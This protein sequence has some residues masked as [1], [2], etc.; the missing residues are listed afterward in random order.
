M[1]MW[2]KCLN[3][4]L[5]Q[6]ALLLPLNSVNVLKSTLASW[7]NPWIVSFLSGNWVSIDCTILTLFYKS[8]IESILT[9]CIVCW[10]GNAS[11]SQG[12]MLRRIIT[13]ASKVLG[14]KQ[15][16]LDEIFKGWALRKAHKI[17]IDPSHPLYLDFELLPSG[18]R[19]R[20]PLSRKN[21]MRQSLCQVISL[22]KSSGDCSHW[23]RKA[24]RLVFSSF[25]CH[26]L[27]L[28][29]YY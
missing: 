8:F 22:L 17:I 13:T 4:G 2:S 3:S 11:V 26:V 15:T 29:S 1:H 19:Y 12:N 5:V 14:I 6:T 21:R 24:S 10:F 25:L 18:R 20:A 16:G 7:W 23:L 9:F 27:F 28:I